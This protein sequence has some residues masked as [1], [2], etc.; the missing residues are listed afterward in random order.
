MWFQWLRAILTK[1][2]F[3][4][5]FIYSST[6]NQPIVLLLFLSLEGMLAYVL[7]KKDL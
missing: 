7:D 6:E 1:D 2:G 3:R 4:L 5:P